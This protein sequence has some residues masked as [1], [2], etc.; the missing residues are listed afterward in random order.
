MGSVFRAILQGERN[1]DM[2]DG[3]TCPS[4]LLCS[5]YL[6]PAGG[7]VEVVVEKL[8]TRLGS[9]GAKVAVFTLE[10]EDR[11]SL[12]DV[13]DVTIYRAPTID[14]TDY[15]G[16]QS[17]L[18]P[19]SF[20]RLRRVLDVENPDV[21][22]IH[23]RFFFTSLATTLLRVL[24]QVD[25]PVVTTLHLGEI[26]EIRGVSG[27]IARAYERT[28]GRGIISSSDA[29]VTVSE[30]VG[31]HARTLG[32]DPSSTY[33]VPNGVDSDQF[34]S[35]S[36]DEDG[37]ATVLFV[38][39]LVKNKGAQV[40]VEAIPEVLEAHADIQF[41][42]VGTGPMERALED[43]VAELGIENHVAFE[44]RIESVSDA[45]RSADLFC[46]PSTTEG[47]PLTLL[48]AMASGLPAVVTPVAGVPEVVEHRETGI[49]VPSED[50]NAVS[51]ALIELLGD[52][53]LRDDIGTAAREYIVRK[54]SW[55]RRTE[56]IKEIYSTVADEN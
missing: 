48:E 27:A 3:S 44:G 14:L 18:S 6:P 38:G 26:D 55:E 52:P 56:R 8:A 2:S 53:A 1:L 17:Q 45:M 43:R 28:F 13:D 4:V 7:G 35:R 22:H 25:V 41:Q 11:P 33:V 9:C 34:S 47:M 40:L 20:T 5:D 12:R 24:R 36:F 39:R 42:I 16:L 15:I 49:L 54:H 19:A 29:V 51:E 21:V 37:P 23:N 30:A 46:R 50:P 32:S 31:E 10:T